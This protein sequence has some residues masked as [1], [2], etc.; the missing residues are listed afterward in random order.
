VA[1]K[2]HTK[3]LVATVKEAQLHRAA[4][5][6]TRQVA[7]VHQL[8][9]PPVAEPAS[10]K[11]TARPVAKKQVNDVRFTKDYKAKIVA[12]VLKGQD[13]GEE[14]VPSI[15]ASEELAPSTIYN[16]VKDAKKAAGVQPKRGDI[17]SADLGSLSRELT[18]AMD[19]VAA[20]KKRMRKL[21]GDD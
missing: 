16:W 7:T 17:K 13:T 4:P 8:P 2:L 6:S 12:R 18:Q 5:P 9:V 15:A 3:P 20:I 1:P 21:L 11:A 14:S 10:E 19:R